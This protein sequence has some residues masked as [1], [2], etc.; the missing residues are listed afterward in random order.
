MA[1]NV[2]RVL[3]VSCSSCLSPVD[4]IDGKKCYI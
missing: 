1:D 3:V 2:G 4:I